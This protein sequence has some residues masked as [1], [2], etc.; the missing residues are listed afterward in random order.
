M[1]IN[2]EGNIDIWVLELA[3]GALSR[4]TTDGSNNH[5]PVW[6]PDG[7]RLAFSSGR[8]RSGDLFWQSVD[9]RGGPE[10]LA[11][12]PQHQDV[13]SW[14]PDGQVL[15]FAEV[16]PV[17][18]WDLWML[19]LADGSTRPFLDTPAQE[20]QPMISPGGRWLAYVSNESGQAEVYLQALPDGGQK[21][22]ISLGGGEEPLWL[23]SRS[24]LLYR[25]GDQV[26]AVPIEAG[27]PLVVGESG[28]CARGTV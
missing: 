26:L 10:R 14:S 5:L 6:T 19:E 18:G 11:Q 27:P 25:H 13:G 24:Q 8:G 15:A 16:H 28:S 22:L 4:F 21:R 2:D 23:P 20:M 9:G 3:R 7:R 12:S 17:T 1:T